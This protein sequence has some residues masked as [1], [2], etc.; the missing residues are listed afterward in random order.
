M[1]RVKASNV[2]EV[3]WLLGAALGSV[4]DL[5]LLESRAARRRSASQLLQLAG[6]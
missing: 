3:I 5:I 4:W 1:K 6:L 2:T